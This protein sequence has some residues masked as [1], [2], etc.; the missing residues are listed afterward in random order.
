MLQVTNNKVMLTDSWYGLGKKA[1]QIYIPAASAAYFALGGIWGLP[2]VD[3]ITGTLAVLAT[4]I[5]VCLGI[6][7]KQF[8]ASDAAFDGKM[9]GHTDDSGKTTYTLEFHGNPEDIVKQDQVHFKV[10]PSAPSS[11]NAPTE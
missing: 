10:E 2:Y 3:K 7:S 9:V 11:G 6:S 8:D 4:F 1:V 5:G